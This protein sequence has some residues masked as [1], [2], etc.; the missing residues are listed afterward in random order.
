[1]A[2][3]LACL[4]GL[5][6]MAGNNELLIMRACGLS[7]SHI[8]SVVTQPVCLI[9]AGTL[10]VAQFVSPYTS[11]FAQSYKAKLSSGNEFVSLKKGIWQSE[12]EMPHIWRRTNGRY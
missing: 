9:I 7:V 6:Q 10:F 5:G 1:M 11:D 12:F 2:T 4:I 3:L 8:L